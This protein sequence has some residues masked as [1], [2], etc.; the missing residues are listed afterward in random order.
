MGKKFRMNHI[1]VNH[2]VWLYDANLFS[3]IKSLIDLNTSDPNALNN[4]EKERL[5][6]YH[7]ELLYEDKTR[8][9]PIPLYSYTR[10]MIATQFILHVLLSLS[11][12]VTEIDLLLH[13]TIRYFFCEAKLIGPSGD[14]ELLQ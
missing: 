4:E 7:E 11:H 5:K 6:F 10:P 1:N 9:R 8:H 12:F 14:P 3:R 13:V 2:L